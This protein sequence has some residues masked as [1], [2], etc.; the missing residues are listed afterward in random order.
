MTT[1]HHIP[2]ALHTILVLAMAA[3]VSPVDAQSF[4]RKPVRWIVPTPPGG[5]AD[6]LSRALG[7]KL[8]ERWGQAVVIENRGGAGGIIGIEAAARAAPDG[9]TLMMGVANFTI[10]AALRDRLPYDPVKDFSPVTLVAVQPF[11]LLVHPSVP[12]RSLKEFIALAKARPGQLNYASTG[13]GGGQ[14]LCMELLKS[15]VGLNV[16]HVPYKGSAPSITDLM[17]GQVQA[18]FTSILS[19]GG[20][21]KSGRLRAL[22]VTTT[23]RSQVFPELPTIAEAGVPGYDYT[24][25]FG[26]L[27][28]AGV[29]AGVMTTLQEDI[30]RALNAPDLKEQVTAQGADIVGSSQEE[31]AQRIRTE[32]P[33]WKKLVSDAKIQ[34]E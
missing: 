3:F 24:S 15:M 16:V 20:H 27:A 5:G 7:Q 34:P 29:P 31:F 25:W 12:A 8:T 13:N 32:I 19:A 22:A 26:V 17:S 1:T 11:L 30:V 4:P 33:K 18:T 2:P 28:P 9:Y 21:I 10:N 6:T 23:K 14:H